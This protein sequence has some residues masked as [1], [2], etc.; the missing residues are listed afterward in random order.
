MKIGFGFNI[1]QK[2]NLLSDTCNYFKWPQ[3]PKTIQAWFRM[4]N[5]LGDCI[6]A[7]PIL[8]AIRKARPDF[9]I[10]LVCQKNL[11]PFLQ[12]YF[13]AEF[14]HVVPQ[15]SGL[16]YFKSFLAIREQYPD[17][18]LNFTNS[19]RSDIEAWCSGSPQRFGLKKGLRPL[20]S[21]VYAYKLKENE[22]QTE[23]WYRFAQNFGL[24]EPLSREPINPPIIPKK[25]K[26]IAL[27]FGSSNT[28]EKRWPVF[29]WQKLIQS[30]L[31]KYPDSKCILL[32]GANEEAMANEI[33]TGL[34][35]TRIND[36]TGQTSLTQ[37]TQI[38]ETVDLVVGNDSGGMHLS[39]FLGIPTVGL[40]GL[41]QPSWGGP[42]YEAPK[43]IIKSSTHNISDL[44][45]DEVF[46]QITS[47]LSNLSSKR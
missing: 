37:L 8:K 20:L 32:G 17:L 11:A 30:F 16:N 36:L 25:I 9:C 40:F 47:W 19:S 27:F 22:H 4:P 46:D 7:Y 41:T 34:P 15:T 24:K 42:F 10:H 23:L 44:S 14:I 39:N 2:R 26:Q 12:R 35:Q 28:P 3:L 18:W 43:C 5:W 13:P 31:Q 1:T 45:E 6:M 33:S 38:L 21:H 29:R